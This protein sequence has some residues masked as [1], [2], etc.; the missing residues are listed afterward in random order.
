QKQTEYNKLLS[1]ENN[2]QNQ[3]K[4][5]KEINEVRPLANLFDT[6]EKLLK[7]HDEIKVNIS[8]QAAYIANLNEQLEKN[9]K[10]FKNHQSLTQSIEKSKIFIENCKLFY[11]KYDKYKTAYLKIG[12]LKNE[13]TNLEDD[14]NKKK[15]YK[16][17]QTLTQTKKKSKIFIENCKLLYT[18]YDKYKTAYLKIGSLK[19]EYTKLEDDYKKDKKQLNTYIAQLNGREPDYKKIEQLNEKIHKLDNDIK[20]YKQNEQHKNE[21]LKLQ[22]KKADKTARKKQIDVNLSTVEEGYQKIDKTNIDLNN[23]QE[24][25]SK[26]QAAIAQGDTCP[27]CGNEVHTLEAQID[28][29]ELT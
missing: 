11:N 24:I 27:V 10:Q 26:I 2:I 6:K 13:Y 1:E 7:K 4:L 17:Q 16:N 3:M 29:D 21:Y 20:T 14:Y 22:E 19:N 15:P 8:K 25:I 12:S 9:K 18:K 5:L 23:K 28:V